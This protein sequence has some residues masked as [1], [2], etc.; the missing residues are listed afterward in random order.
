MEDYKTT[1]AGKCR[2]ENK[3]Q[4]ERFVKWRSGKMQSPN[5]EHQ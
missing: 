3:G 4:N 2:I 1:T 5:D